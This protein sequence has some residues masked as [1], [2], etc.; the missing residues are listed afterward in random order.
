MIISSATVRIMKN[1]CDIF[2]KTLCG[3]IMTNYIP[4]NRG[5]GSVLCLCN[6]KAKLAIKFKDKINNAGSDT[7]KKAYDNVNFNFAKEVPDNGEKIKSIVCF[8]V[9]PEYRGNGVATTLLDSICQDAKADGYVIVE[10]YPFQHN[11][12]HAYHGPLTMYKK[13]GFEL[14]GK[15]DECAICRKYL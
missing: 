2:M 13:N 9:A 4:E 8:S 5:M 11:K 14:C 6:T 1:I 15:I 7:D 10:A 3:G 12:Y